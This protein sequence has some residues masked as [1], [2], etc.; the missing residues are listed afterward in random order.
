ARSIGT[1]A[2]SGNTTLGLAGGVSGSHIQVFGTG[3]LGTFTAKGTVSDTLIEALAGSVTSFTAAAFVG[4]D[5]LVG[6]VLASQGDLAGV[7]F[8]PNQSIGTFKTTGSFADSNVAAAKLGTITL[9]TVNPDSNVNVLD[10]LFAS[11]SFGLG[12]LNG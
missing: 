1:F 8:G 10:M 11:S 7:T 6:A 3:G 5:L 9:G 2:V 12:F 4:S